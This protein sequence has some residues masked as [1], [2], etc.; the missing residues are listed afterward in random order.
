MTR[1]KI[2]FFIALLLVL[3]VAGGPA[4]ASPADLTGDWILTDKDG[5][6]FTMEFGAKGNSWIAFARSKIQV[7]LKLNPSGLRNQWVGNL[8]L[9]GKHDVKAAM[10]SPTKLVVTDLDSG[11][12]WTLKRE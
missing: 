10:K 6:N 1:S 2:P 8:L 12:S 7:K 3:S 5:T 4:G 11:E 9:D